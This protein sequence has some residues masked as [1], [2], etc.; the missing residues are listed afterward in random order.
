MTSDA[1]SESFDGM[2]RLIDRLKD[3]LPLAQMNA[4]YLKNPRFCVFEGNSKDFWTRV[5]RVILIRR[6]LLQGR[7]LPFL[8]E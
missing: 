5:K 3:G 1:S 7:V 6:A 2:N 4:E 8:P